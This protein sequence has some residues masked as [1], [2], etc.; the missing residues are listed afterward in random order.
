MDWGKKD[1][2]PMPLSRLS[3]GCMRLVEDGVPLMVPQAHKLVY[4]CLEAGITTFEVAD[5]YG[6]YSVE[7]LLGKVLERDHAL[8][9]R[10]ELVVKAGLVAPSEKLKPAVRV[11]QSNSGVD[12]L[13]RSVDRSLELLRVEKI[14]LLLL[15][16]FDPLTS[17]EEVADALRELK[18]TGKVKHFGLA[19]HTPSQARLLAS[20]VGK[21]TPL[22]AMEF[23]CSVLRPGAILDGTLDLCAE[24]GLRPLF[25]APLAGG[26]LF[27]KPKSK[28]HVRVLRAIEET[29]RELSAVGVEAPTAS[30]AVAFLLALPQGGSALLGT[31]DTAHLREA[32]VAVT[33][34]LNREQWYRIFNAA[35]GPDPA[36]FRG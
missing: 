4:Q 13:V 22:V 32:N 27:R 34:A 25:A 23:E 3:Y 29:A 8:R 9:P 28:Q 11:R 16:T 19:G 5:Y 31:R 12:H 21:H 18:K 17:A 24:L 30:V 7:E 35:V 14:D 6:D 1:S 15:H 33:L 26:E 10:M 2:A 36:A 20:R